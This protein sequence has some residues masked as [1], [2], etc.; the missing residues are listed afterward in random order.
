MSLVAQRPSDIGMNFD[1]VRNY[2][3]SSPLAYIGSFSRTYVGLEQAVTFPLCSKKKAPLLGE[4]GV[5]Y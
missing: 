3:S 4:E 5:L 2:D 1:K